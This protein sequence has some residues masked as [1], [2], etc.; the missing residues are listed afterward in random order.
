MNDHFPYTMSVGM[1]SPHRAF[2]SKSLYSYGAHPTIEYM[3]MLST[4]SSSMDHNIL[5]PLVFVSHSHSSIGL[6]RRSLPCI[7]VHR[8]LTTIQTRPCESNGK[9]PNVGG[10]AGLFPRMSSI[11]CRISGVSL[12]STSIAFIFSMTGLDASNNLHPDSNVPKTHSVLGGM[13]RGSLCL[14]LGCMQPTPKQAGRQ[15]SRAHPPPM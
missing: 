15:C 11:F 13:R 10:G 7:S 6:Q 1:L 5:W 3:C 14:C 2:F 8:L 4:A 9:R 12:G